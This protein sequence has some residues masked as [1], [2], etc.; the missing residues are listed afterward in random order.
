MVIALFS[1]HFGKKCLLTWIFVTM[2]MNHNVNIILWSFKGH[3][4]EVVS[5]VLVYAQ[6]PTLREFELHIEWV[7][8]VILIVVLHIDA[9]FI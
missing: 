1:K 5:E 8:V 6:F 3:L 7:I 2:I 4:S 9:Q